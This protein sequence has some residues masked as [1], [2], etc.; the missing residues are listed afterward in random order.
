MVIG[1]LGIC[2]FLVF[3]ATATLMQPML[4]YVL[5]GWRAKRKD[6]MD[7]LTP[8]ARRTYFQMFGGDETVPLDLTQAS[9]RFEDLYIEWYG[10]RHFI[11]PGV[12]LLLVGLTATAS[13]VFTVLGQGI[14]PA[15]LLFN[16][17]QTAIAALAGAYL[18][19]VNDHIN[20]AR[21]LD[22]SPA[23][24]MWAVLRLTIAVPMGYAL[25]GFFSREAGPFIAFAFGAFPLSELIAMLR[26]LTEKQL[27]APATAD[28]TSDDLIK[29]QGINKAILERLANEDV[30]TISQI[31]YCD[32][33]RL[34]MR[35]NLSFNFILDCI[36]QALAWMY[37]ESRLDTIRPFGLRGAVEIKWLMR[38]L[39]GEGDGAEDDGARQK[40]AVLVQQIAAAINLSSQTLEFA[41]EQIADDP[42]TIF[43]DEIW[44]LP[45]CLGDDSDEDT[46]EKS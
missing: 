21:R 20:R 5:V 29:L 33:V 40:A 11:I 24:V 41:F 12:L 38:D 27:N 19:V 1:P 42:Y 34:T 10:R 25:S 26:N 15:N 23:D 35:S 36:N 22:F 44:Q 43:Q 8:S 32:P 46:Q 17:P 30:T 9:K 45:E 18:W 2:L 6:I 3:C 7:G 31:A 39:K 16:L 13:V 14:F 37:L 4:R 28:E